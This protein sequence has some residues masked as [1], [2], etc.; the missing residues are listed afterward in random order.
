MSPPS[1]LRTVA[2]TPPSSSV[3]WNAATAARVLGF[4]GLSSTWF[5][6]IRLK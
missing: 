3:F 6:G 1:V 2:V 5:N 4:R